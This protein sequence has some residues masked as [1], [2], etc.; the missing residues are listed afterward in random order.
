MR[1]ILKYHHVSPRAAVTGVGAVPS[2]VVQQPTKV[3]SLQ[4]MVTLSEL[5][6][7]ETFEDVIL[8]SHAFI[9]V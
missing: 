6:D 9:W 3:L 1:E 2:A 4:N 7:D 8:P 5:E